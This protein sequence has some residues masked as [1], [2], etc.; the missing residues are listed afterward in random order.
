MAPAALRPSRRST[1][2]MTA[3]DRA[4]TTTSSETRP[5]RRLDI[6]AVRFAAIRS[7][8]IATVL[9]DRYGRPLPHD[10][11]GRDDL[12]LLI[13]HASQF[14]DPRLRIGGIIDAWAP[15][16]TAD[17]RAELEREALAAPPPRY[18]PDEIAQRL[19][20]TMADR[21]R[22]RLTSIGATDA[23]KAERGRLRKV[24]RAARAREL[25]REVRDRV[26]LLGARNSAAAFGA[27]GSERQQA[28]L[29]ALS[30][31]TWTEVK[32]LAE[33]VA[34]WSPFKELGARAVLRRIINRELDRL[35]Q[36][37]LIE[38]KCLPGRN[39]FLSRRVVKV[40]TESVQ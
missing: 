20:V 35:G 37:Q 8:E 27:G 9:E 23:D 16:V 39:S 2:R 25:R 1:H 11:A 22:L 5:G 38:S 12:R 15:W 10:D 6:D 17:E 30:G 13:E 24:R 32:E 34:E 36:R 31:S 18:T 33:I 29:V 26:A 19:G 21:L 14:H 3:P 4:S 40:K 28:L 7:R